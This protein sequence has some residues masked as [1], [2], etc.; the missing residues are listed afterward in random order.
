MTKRTWLFTVTTLLILGLAAC[1][2]G[3][4]GGGG[5]SIPTATNAAIVPPPTTPLTITTGGGATLTANE[6]IAANAFQASDG[7]LNNAADPASGVVTAQAVDSGTQAKR[8]TL[9]AIVR[10]HAERIKD[11]EPAVTAAPQVDT[12]QCSGG[13]TDTL[14]VDDATQKV[15]EV[16]VNCNDGTQILFGTLASSNVSAFQ[17]LGA[18]VGSPYV[19]SVTA[20]LTIDLA[21]TKGPPPSVVTQGSFTFMLTINGTM[22]ANGTG[23]VRP[24]PANTVALSMNGQSLLSSNGT[25]RELLSNF[26]ITVLDEINV[27]RASVGANYTYASTTING[28]VMVA[29]TTVITF[30]PQDAQRPSSGIV[31]ITAPIASGPPSGAKIVLTVLSATTGVHVDVYDAG[32][33][34]ADQADLTWDQVDHL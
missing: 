13:G 19:E 2:G 12:Q 6:S 7:A 32:G 5:A 22:Q 4:G 27:S 15:T 18:T 31:M 1:S 26:S 25:V 20:S 17:S 8:E 14:V 21:V 23:G 33:V 9:A 10:R 11:H 16:F 3:G 29:T 28:A 24:G 34:I 30:Q